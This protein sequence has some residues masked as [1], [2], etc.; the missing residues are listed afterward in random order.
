MFFTETHIYFLVFYTGTCFSEKDFSK[1]FQIFSVKTA[2]SYLLSK[3]FVDKETF[4]KKV[5]IGKRV[6]V[7]IRSINNL[8]FE[9]RDNPFGT[10]P[11]LTEKL[12]FLTP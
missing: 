1:I 4:V 5:E 8:C 12:T 3:Y 10:Y 2:G 11:K 7:R 9:V 6:V